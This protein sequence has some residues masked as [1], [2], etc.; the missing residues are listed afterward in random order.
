MSAVAET[1]KV[2]LCFAALTIACT[3]NDALNGGS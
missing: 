3:T 2:A 1:R